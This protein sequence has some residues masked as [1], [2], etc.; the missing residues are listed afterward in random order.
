M[1]KL[2]KPQ[3]LKTIG[4]KKYKTSAKHN[5]AMKLRYAKNKNKIK[6]IP[7]V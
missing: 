7:K 6:K 3:P 1:A 2:G 4:P 5:E